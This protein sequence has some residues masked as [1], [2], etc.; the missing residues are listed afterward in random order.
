[1]AF[2]FGGG[3]KTNAASTPNYTGMQLQSSA[4]GLVVPVV[5]GTTRIGWNLLDYV[6]FKT[7]TT[8]SSSGG[9]GGIVGGGGGKGS[10]S[11]TTSYTATVAG[12]LCEGPIH[13]VYSSWSSQTPLA[14]YP[15]FTVFTGA[16]AQTVWSW[17]AANGFGSHAVNYSGFAY[18]AAANYNLGSSANFPNMNWEVQA[19]LWNTAPGTYGGNGCAT[20]GDADPSQIIPDILT[21]TKYGVGFPSARVGQVN[22]WNEAHSG[23]TSITVTHASTFN[24]NVSVYDA[25]LSISLTCV[26]GTPAANQYSFTTAGAYTFNAAQNGH[27]LTINYVTVDAMTNYQNFTMASGLWMSPAYTSQSQ[28]SSVLDDIAKATYSEVLWSSG[29]LQMVPRGTQN[30]TANGFTFT[31]NITPVYALGPDDFLDGTTGNASDP[32]TIT[33]NRKADQLNVI[34]IEALDRANQYAPAVIEMTDQAQIDQYGRRAA[35]SQ[36]LHHFCDL[37]AAKT[38]AALQLQDT[39]ILNQYAFN[40]DERY[41]V[42]DPMDIVTLTDPSYPGLTNIGVRI[43]DMTENDDG[44]ISIIA[45][46]FPGTIGTVPTYH[47]DPGSGTIQNFNADPGNAAAPAVFD[48]PVQL[49]NATN[50]ETWLATCSATGNANWGGCDVYLSADNTTFVK[51]G[52]LF[53]PSRM[54]VTTATFAIGSDPDTVNTLSVDLTNSFGALLGGTQADADQ[55]N[56]LCFVCNTDGTNGEYVSYQQATLTATYKYDLGKSGASPGYLRRGQW[57]TSPVAHPS[58]SLFVRLDDNIFTMPYTPADVGKTLYIKLVSFN[59][60]GAGYQSLGS[61]TSYAHTIA[62]PPIPPLVQNFTAAQNGNAI[63]LAW[64]DLTTA[65]IKGYDI[66]FG[67]V[68]GT[69][70]TATLLSEAS[71]QTAETTVGVP[72]GTWVMYIRGRNIANQYGPASSSTVT[73]SNTNITIGS[74]KQEPDWL[75]TLSGYVL[76]YTGVLVP[77]SQTL[78]SACTYAQ[79]ACGFNPVANP[80]YTAPTYDEGFNSSSRIFY[81]ISGRAAGA[82]GLAPSLASYLD[83]WLSGFSDPNTYIPWTVGS[84]LSRYNNFRVIDQAPAP[85]VLTQFDITVDAPLQDYV[86]N[87]FAVSSLGTVLNFA[88]NNIGPFH[89]TP[90]VQVTPVDGVGTGGGAS[91]ISATQATITEYQG[92]AAINGTVNLRISGN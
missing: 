79:L 91:P 22:F 71:R 39:Y 14:G 89:N 65:G 15:N 16:L 2:F 36:S 60:W 74:F 3:G 55:D 19:L 46:E 44:T 8:P 9:K 78:A 12:V 27:A 29:V 38:C 53:A 56:T 42:L 10:S 49:A 48:V 11:S 30:I 6:N 62:G 28:A 85:Q 80:T 76:H 45:E 88:A 63:A 92:V 50:L 90:N 47:I 43:I 87:G 54:G 31:A 82:S 84:V 1:M 67:P 81:T 21:N 70:A 7:V 75:G 24:Y 13:G 33:R 83:Y 41:I 51:K 58:G 72:P 40:V 69:V 68:G 66:L 18:A 4:Y 32:V 5:Y 37:Q 35:A 86:I 57:G 52:T 23:A 59:I 77:V 17:W 26:A 61:V 64:T 20:G 73:V 25:N 34:K